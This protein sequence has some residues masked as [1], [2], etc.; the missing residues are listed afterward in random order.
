MDLSQLIKLKNKQLILKNIDLTP[1]GVI[2]ARDITFSPRFNQIS[3]IT[4]TVDK[5]N[6]EGIYNLLTSRRVIELQDVAH[7]I[8]ENPVNTEDGL[9]ESMTLTCRSYEYDVNRYTIPL[10]QG[11]YKFYSILPEDETIMKIIMSYLP[12]WSI[13][14]V[15]SSLWNVYRTFDLSDRPLY[16]AL[17]EDFSKAYEAI[18]VFD[19]LNFKIK[20]IAYEN[21]IKSS[22]IY[23]SFENLVN[24]IDITEKTEELI[25]ALSVFGVGLDIS[26][27]NPL[28]NTIYD[29]SYFT[30]TVDNVS[31]LKF[32]SDS[33]I[34]AVKNWEQ[35]I[36]DYQSDYSDYLTQ[37]KSKLLEKIVLESELVDLKGELK[38]L[39]LVRDALLESEQSATSANA[40]VIAKQNEI[41]AKELAIKNKQIE[42]E[43]IEDDIRNIQ[44]I[45][46]INSNFN[47]E[48][49]KELERF[50]IHQSVTDDNFV[51]SE[52]DDDA[53]IQQT[54]QDLYDKYKR[55]LSKN[56]DLK[57]EFLIDLQNFIPY[58]EYQL[59]TSQLEFGKEITLKNSRGKLSYPL[60]MGL[61]ISLDDNDNEVQY[62]F[63]TEMRL[64]S[65]NDEYNDY[66][67][68]TLTSVA[69][70]VT[71][72]SLSWGQYV[73]SGA[74]DRVDSL[75]KNG[76]NLDLTEVM[77]ATGQE[78]VFDITGFLGR[79][80]LENGSY[81]DL[82]FKFVNNKLIFTRD[83]WNTCALAI[84]EVT[85]PDGS[86]NF[87]VNS[88][89]LMGQL[90]AGEQ[91]VIKNANNTFVVD[92]DGA[93]LKDAVMELIGNNDKNRVLIDPVNG[94]KIQKWLDTEW[95]DV[96]YLDSEGNAI[97]EANMTVGSI[98]INNKFLVDNLGN[99]T[100]LS[101]NFDIGSGNFAV[102]TN[103]NVSIQG[104][105]NVNNGSIIVDENGNFNIDGFDVSQTFIT[106]VLTADTGYIAQLTVDQLE[107]S[108][109]V[110]KYLVSD[111]SDV[112]YIKIYEQHF[113]W[114]TASTDGLQKEQAKDRFGD[115]L[116]WRDLTH[117]GTTTEMTSYPVWI[118]K[119]TEQI[120][121]EI[122]FEEVMGTYVPKIIL[123]LGDGTGDK[124][125][126]AEIWKGITG[127]ELNYYCSNTGELRQLLLD[128]YG[129]QTNIPVYNSGRIIRNII[130]TEDDPDPSMGEV[131]DIII[132][133]E[134]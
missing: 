20:V 7:F 11:T 129:I 57:Y 79:K 112:N 102:D 6:N 62:L 75:F 126:K 26:L 84:G 132:Q 76:L 27:V 16:Q 25:T 8:I 40:N 99:V 111:I 90:I 61:D 105:L 45:V 83:N 41:N 72:S 33:L 15:D 12:N 91:L 21:V 88:E 30:D 46:S 124:H 13:E 32:M 59:F 70:K 38:G 96:V 127:L 113:Y 42:L 125:A 37:R 122:S 109:K 95:V 108:T 80:K 134:G 114:I 104:T 50:I 69:N 120:K 97:F 17:Q 58:E 22:D 118:Y 3:E 81:S 87:G 60:L 73:N 130:V 4:F 56:K 78:Q 19:T 93:L 63:S 47:S 1:I 24:K 67:T 23:L 55:L 29:F 128:D 107:T 98:N 28:G 123:G 133:I 52:I 66:L 85:L 36:N 100:I 110:Q 49:I 34:L 106:Q 131:N 44:N 116:Y 115:N 10:L 5:E 86:K 77:S 117:K 65:A 94:F 89:V 48:Q 2:N 14:S 35:L 51:K 31:G 92:S 9:S 54:A 103:G 74:K 101:G 119:Y 39:I 71:G 43:N 18:F 64:R 68:N 53:T 121:L 82:Q